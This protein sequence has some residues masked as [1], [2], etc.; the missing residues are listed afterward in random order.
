MVLKNVVERQAEAA[1]DFDALTDIVSDVEA[2]LILFCLTDEVT[3][4]REWML[5]SFIPDDCRVRDKML[6]AGSKEDLKKAL[7]SGYFRSDYSTS[8]RDELTWTIFTKS[9]DKSVSNDLL[10]DKEKLLD[11]ER[12]MR[13]H[14]TNDLKS[15]A[16]GVLPFNMTTD[17]SQAFKDFNSG[18][19][20][21]I[22]LTIR[23]EIITLISS[24]TVKSGEKLH[25][26]I[27]AVEP[28]FY[29][30]NL[31]NK[32]LF[33]FSCPENAHVRLKMTMAA[34]RASVHASAS[35][36]GIIFDTTIGISSPEEIDTLFSETSNSLFSS[37]AA[38]VTQTKPRAPG[39]A[40]NKTKAKF[41]ADSD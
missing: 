5:I 32:R 35:K 4:S 19:K 14:E 15:T 2:T 1:T 23:S 36:D 10:S 11:E 16:M 20:N 33:V 25:S 9:N 40:V 21:F 31:E 6:Y 3:P 37:A 13:V 41:I 17:A 27:N 8:N 24:K 28:T 7:G 39:R 12:N 38:N 30:I 22:E 26:L 34:S 29:F 18:A